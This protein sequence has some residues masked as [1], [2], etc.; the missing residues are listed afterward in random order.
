MPLHRFQLLVRLILSFDTRRVSL[1]NGS[2]TPQVSMSGT[3]ART[4]AWWPATRGD[5]ADLAAHR[6]LR[7]PCGA[8]PLYTQPCDV[9][10]AMK[11]ARGYAAD[12]M[13][14]RIRVGDE[15]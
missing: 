4:V 8:R 2:D 6:P 15:A 9:W 13:P 5:M 14:I 11:G 7:T 3:A 12:A 10:A 1:L